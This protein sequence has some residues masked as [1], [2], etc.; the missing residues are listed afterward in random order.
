MPD[1]DGEMTK[2]YFRQWGRLPA[3]AKM[4]QAQRRIETLEREVCERHIEEWNR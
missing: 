3:D 2:V 4:E 1:T